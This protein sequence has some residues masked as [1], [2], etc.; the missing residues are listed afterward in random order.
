MSRTNRA[1]VLADYLSYDYAEIGDYRYQPSQHSSAT[2]V[3][4]IGDYYYT[5]VKN[6]GRKA[7]GYE[8]VDVTNDYIRFKYPDAKV[9]MAGTEV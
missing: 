9:F 5:V 1:L 2:P 8:W 6:N 3:W 7:G 4:A